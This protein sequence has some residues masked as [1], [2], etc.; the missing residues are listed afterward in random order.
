MYVQKSVCV[1]EQTLPYVGGEIGGSVLLL[2]RSPY[3]LIKTSAFSQ[4]IC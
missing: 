3:F 4:S 2:Q 1:N